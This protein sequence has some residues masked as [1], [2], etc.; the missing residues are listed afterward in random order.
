MA[1]RYEKLEIVL[2]SFYAKYAEEYTS[3]EAYSSDKFIYDN[4]KQHVRDK[5]NKI[6]AIRKEEIR[7]KKELAAMI[8]EGSNQVITDED[9][10]NK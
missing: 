9:K 5:Y 7:N 8:Q 2:D 6:Q 10:I 3:I 1:S 4:D